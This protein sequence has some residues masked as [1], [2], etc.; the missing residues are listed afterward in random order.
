MHRWI[1]GA[2]VALLSGPSVSAQAQEYPTRVVRAITNLS[3]GG[4]SDIFMRAL[5]EELHK[6]WGKP[7][8]V[9]NRPGGTQNIGVR[10]CQDAAPDGYTICILL[11]DALVY[12]PHLFKSLPFN[13][14]AVQPVMNLFYIIQTIAVNSSLGVKTMDE[15]VA[16]SK[17]KPGT[18]SYQS[19]SPAPALYMEKLKAEKGADWVRV[20][21]K[22]GADSVNAMLTGATPIS[23]LGEANIIG[24]I[25]AGTITPLA[26]VNNIRS[27][28]F[29]NVPTLEE[30]GYRGA[31]SRAWFGLY[32]PT[33][34]PAPIIDKIVKDIAS[35]LAD[36]VFKE[37][38]LTARSLVP[39]SNV[40]AKFAEEV[41]KDRAEAGE[42]VRAAGIELQ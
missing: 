28:N 12:N 14:S 42:V 2:L 34:T 31:P 24:H 17:A 16:Y 20:P 7:I 8:V 13:E 15:L 10:A 32:V 41:A 35:V 1:F 3:A 39:G 26:M 21:F 30:L 19:A 40:G 11:S 25:R 23:I 18:L 29:T 38:L 27:P 37:R 33:G 6:R 9:E 22:G 4:L 5:G 36:P